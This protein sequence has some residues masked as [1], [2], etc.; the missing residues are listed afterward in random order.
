MDPG[1]SSAQGWRGGR[2]WGA[3][4]TPRMKGNTILG[5]HGE[6]RISLIDVP[7]PVRSRTS[8]AMA[9]LN[10]ASPR[11]ETV[12]PTQRSVNGRERNARAKCSRSSNEGSNYI[13][14]YAVL[15]RSRRY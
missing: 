3:T 11:T 7:E 5:A 12:C 13:L 6:M 4:I 9:T 2:E 10:T 8:Q 14:D 1:L 15:I